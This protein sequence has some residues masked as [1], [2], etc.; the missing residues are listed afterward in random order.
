MSFH[1]KRYVY[2]IKSQGDNIPPLTAPLVIDTSKAYFRRD[3]TAGN[4][5]CGRSPPKDNEPSTDNLDV[6]MDFFETNIWPQ[7]AYRIPAFESLKVVGSWAGFYEFNKFDC[8]GILGKHPAYDNFYIMAGYSGHGIQKIPAVGR[9]IAE[10][11]VDGGFK[12]IDLSLLGFD[13]VVENKPL[14]ELALV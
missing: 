5:I 14:V 4:F 7:L 1:S 9:G 13:R 3:G 12:T 8:N 6:D 11:I 2:V 10:L